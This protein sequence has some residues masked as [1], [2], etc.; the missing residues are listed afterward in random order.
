MKIN[1]FISIILCTLLF[2]VGCASIGSDASIEDTSKFIV[3]DIMNDESKISK[4][5]NL[6]VDVSGDGE[7]LV[8]FKNESSENIDHSHAIYLE[9]K[10]DGTWYM[11]PEI[12]A[13]ADESNI[14]E[15]NKEFT[16][17]VKLDNWDVTKKGIFRMYKKYYSTDANRPA[18]ETEEYSISNEF[19]L[20]E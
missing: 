14:L 19:E 7:L 20:K 1:K 4:D 2:T 12:A 11:I 5:V 13:Y 16:Q 9:K 15:P 6:S 8:S 3:S 17:T 10:I 18:S